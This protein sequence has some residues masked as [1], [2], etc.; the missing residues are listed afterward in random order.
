M[1]QY[2]SRQ[3][4]SQIFMASTPKVY[5]LFMLLVNRAYSIPVT[6][7]TRLAEGSPRTLQLSL[8]GR[9]RKWLKNSYELFTSLGGEA[10]RSLIKHHGQN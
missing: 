7:G 8:C 5:C 6:L 10:N 9:G 4:I 2:S 1:L 3:L